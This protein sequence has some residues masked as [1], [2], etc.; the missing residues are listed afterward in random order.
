[1]P[2]TDHVTEG[3]GVF[4]TRAVSAAR[5]FNE[6]V[7]EPGEIATVTLLV[8]VTLAESV[9]RAVEPELAVAWIVTEFCDGKVIGAV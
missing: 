2:S 1:M 4:V 7:A 9:A 3:S 5:W 6:R 8:I